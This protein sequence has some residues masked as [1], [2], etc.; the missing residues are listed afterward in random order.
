[1]LLGA[2][3]LVLLH[4]P[5]QPA[6]QHSARWMALRA[7]CEQRRQCPTSSECAELPSHRR[8]GNARLSVNVGL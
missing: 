3:L 8:A 7:S 4:S 5:S 1:V 2:A 6:P